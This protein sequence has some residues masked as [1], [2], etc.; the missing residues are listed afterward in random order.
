[1]L[2]LKSFASSSKGNCYQLVDGSSSLLIEAGIQFK[3]IQ[4]ALGFEVSG[5]DGCLISHE[6][7]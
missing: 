7:L 6:H 3:R 5:L 2:T 4:V 1:M